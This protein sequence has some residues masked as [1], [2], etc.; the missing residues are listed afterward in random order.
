MDARALGNATRGV[1][2]VA[3][4]AANATLAG[5]TGTGTINDDD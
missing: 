1:N 4:P 3:A 2:G 5:A